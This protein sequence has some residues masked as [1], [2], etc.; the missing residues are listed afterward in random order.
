MK[1]RRR[2]LLIA[3]GLLLCGGAVCAWWFFSRTGTA[4]ASDRFQVRAARRAYDGAPPVIPHPPLG[5][6][7]TDCHA[8]TARD[9]P[10]VGIAPPNPHLDTPGMSAARCRQCH[11]FRQTEELFV[12]TAF[13]GLKQVPR[14]G[15]R[16]YADAPPVIPHHL[17]MRENCNACHSGPAAR[18]EIR[19]SHPDRVRCLQ[20]HARQEGLR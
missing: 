7:C 3:L 11:V 13:E 19:C 20:C 14:K 9:L 10:G 15:G 5:G 4:R 2:R 6:T 18:E 12:P 1:N 8:S 17:F 16:M